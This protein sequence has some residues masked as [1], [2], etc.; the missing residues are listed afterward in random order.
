MS[1]EK[2]FW[3][4]SK[5][6]IL[7]MAGSAIGLGNIWRFSYIMGKYG[8]AAFFLT[9]IGAIFFIG[10]PIMLCELALGRASQSGPLDAMTKLAPAKT[11]LSKLL[12]VLLFLGAG[13]FVFAG[14][15]THA[16]L[17]ALL[18]VGAL[19]YGWGTLGFAATYLTPLMISVF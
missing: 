18:G 8:G 9:Y 5:G 16:V 2:E 19:L 3:S 13:C 15:R 6:F 10:L 1:S 4:S 11:K 14:M 17:T 7:A 12:A